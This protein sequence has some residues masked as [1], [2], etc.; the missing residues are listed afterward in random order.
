MLK[1]ELR[2][3]ELKRIKNILNSGLNKRFLLNSNSSKN[4]ESRFK[5]K[6]DITINKLNYDVDKLALVI[7]KIIE[8][9][10][11]FVSSTQTKLNNRTILL[12]ENTVNVYLNPQSTESIKSPFYKYLVYPDCID[13]FLT[14]LEELDKFVPLDNNSILVGFEEINEFNYITFDKCFNLD[15]SDLNNYFVLKYLFGIISNSYEFVDNYYGKVNKN[16]ILINNFM[17]NSFN[18]GTSANDLFYEKANISE[19]L[20]EEKKIRAKKLI[21]TN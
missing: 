4:F 3:K 16:D 6:G 12:E 1:N 8:Q 17:I 7:L 11:E 5:D 18:I 9:L 13:A 10:G 21:N 19:K 14:D 2:E 15:I 20:N